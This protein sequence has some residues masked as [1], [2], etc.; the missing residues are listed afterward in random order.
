MTFAGYYAIG[1]SGEID[2]NKLLIGPTIQEFRRVGQMSR[3]RSMR[4]GRTMR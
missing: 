3:L 2:V 1:Q 4:C